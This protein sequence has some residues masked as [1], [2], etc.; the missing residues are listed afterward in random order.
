MA[1]FA[2][3]GVVAAGEALED[4][5][6]APATE[7]ERERTVGLYLHT[8]SQSVKTCF[9]MNVR[10]TLLTQGVCLGSGIGNLEEMYN[11]SV[12]FH[13]NGKLP[14]NRHSDN[15]LSLYTGYKKTHPLF[16]PRLLINLGASHISMKYG[17]KV[18]HP[19]P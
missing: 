16:V 15:E 17:L 4:A 13:E 18:R 10:L 12:A 19:L 14:S 8:A 1:K 3:Y 11:T 6:W 9:V 5:G 7:S 2:Q